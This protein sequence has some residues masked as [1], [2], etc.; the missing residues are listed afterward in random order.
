MDVNLVEK[1]VLML[2]E[3]LVAMKVVKFVDKMVDVLD[4][5]LVT[6]MVVLKVV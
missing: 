5:Q 6:V 4:L 2:D 3:T 1:K